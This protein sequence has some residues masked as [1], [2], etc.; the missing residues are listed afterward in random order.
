MR[1]TNLNN[2]VMNKEKVVHNRLFMVLPDEEDTKYDYSDGLFEWF[3][4]RF[5]YYG[6]NR[7]TFVSTDVDRDKTKGN[8]RNGGADIFLNNGVRTNYYC[9]YMLMAFT[10]MEHDEIML[11]YVPPVTLKNIVEYYYYK[12]PDK[13]NF[14]LT[15]RYSFIKERIK[16]MKEF[17][18]YAKSIKLT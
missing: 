9:V 8:N 18:K 7:E 6:L 13:N 1:K 15:E 17:L 4:D 14:N 10:H 16:S 3:Y 12:N 2:V 11:A 5:M